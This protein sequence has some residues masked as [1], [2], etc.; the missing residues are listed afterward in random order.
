MTIK[1]FL[2]GGAY[3][4]YCCY[5]PYIPDMVSIIEL[6]NEYNCI[7]QKNGVI[8]PVKFRNIVNKI[9]KKYR[10]HKKR[11]IKHRKKHYETI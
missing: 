4:Y 8:S 6:W 7:N 9:L 1:K 3:S 5:L 2:Q 11:V 10:K